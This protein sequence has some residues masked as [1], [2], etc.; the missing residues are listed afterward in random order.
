MDR[1]ELKLFIGIIIFV[2]ASAVFYDLW[3]FLYLKGYMFY[4]K[5]KISGTDVDADR[6]LKNFSYYQKL[7]PHGKEAFVYRVLYF[8]SDKYFIGRED[9]KVTDEMR[10]LI[11]ASA[12]QLT[13]GLKEYSLDNIGSVNIFPGIF[14]S[15][16]FNTKFKGL[17]SAN[18]VLSVSW[19]DF[20]KGYDN[21][22]DNYNLGL[23]EMAHSLKL[24]VLYG[25]GFDKRFGGYIDDWENIGT[26]IFE[27]IKQT[28]C[29]YLRDY[30]A[31][32][33]HEF[34]AVC[35]ECF[36]ETPVKFRQQMPDLFNH[37]CILLNQDPVNVNGDYEISAA[38]R[39]SVN[40]N[41]NLRPIPEKIIESLKYSKLHWSRRL[42][43]LG[44]VGGVFLI[45]FFKRYTLITETSLL[46]I[47]LFASIA[48]LSQ[49][50]YFK[51]RKIFTPLEFIGFCFVGPAP[52]FVALLLMLNFFI[53]LSS[54]TSERYKIE[55]ISTDVFEYETRSRWSQRSESHTDRMN[56]EVF[57]ENMQYEEYS[58]IRTFYIGFTP[59]IDGNSLELDFQRG[60]FGLKALK[61]FRFVTINE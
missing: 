8:I 52:C 28:K 60:V 55:K 49:W 20:K 15:K 9:L 26:S 45:F 16:R 7:S 37:L 30:A 57:L 27:N 18:G 11:A 10:V 44:L 54:K 46:L 39:E 36:F 40:R 14:F 29:I 34:F 53:P 43:Y 38:Y 50:N 41:V 32:N 23:H 21:P 47:Y 58:S 4:R 5:V 42:I 12:V 22:D 35:V 61:D 24:S 1:D 51:R 48:A 59:D 6:Y 19:D 2:I 31:S 3:K 17:T 33:R 56:Y 25:S 13:F